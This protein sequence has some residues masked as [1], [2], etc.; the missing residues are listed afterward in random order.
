MNNGEWGIWDI[1]KKHERD[2]FFLLY[3]LGGFLVSLFRL[4]YTKGGGE[5]GEGGSEM[6][7]TELWGMGGLQFVFFFFLF[8]CFFVLFFYVF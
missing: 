7:L 8:V 3:F 4:V 6:F 2:L 5:G 1:F